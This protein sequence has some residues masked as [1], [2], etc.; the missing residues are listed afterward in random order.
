MT[1]PNTPSSR[2]RLE[3][4]DKDWVTGRD[5]MTGILVNVVLSTPILL[6]QADRGIVHEPPS[7]DVILGHL[8]ILRDKELGW[9]KFGLA[10]RALD[11]SV[12][13]RVSDELA[14]WRENETD[15]T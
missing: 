3:Q 1:E 13:L 9:E 8:E 11:M 7:L 14:R 2:I 4:L 5:I 6:Q 12:L 10:I 15:E